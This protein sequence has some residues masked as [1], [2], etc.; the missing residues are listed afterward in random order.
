MIILNKYQ[1][2]NKAP[3]SISL[4][5][6]LVFL[7][8]CNNNPAQ[9][10]TSTTEQVTNMDSLV[11]SGGNQSLTTQSTLMG[12]TL[13]LGSIEV[14]NWPLRQAPCTQCEVQLNRRHHPDGPTVWLNIK[15]EGN[16]KTWIASSFK[17]QF[18]IDHWQFKHNNHQ[19][20]ISDS[21][22]KQKTTIAENIQSPIPLSPDNKCSVLWA[23]KKYLSQPGANISAD[24]AQFSSQFVI[25]CEQ[26][27]IQKL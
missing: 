15:G 14:K 4:L 7:Y 18:N 27:P 22:S 24:V 12:S 2:I 6:A 10:D 13:V 8:G 11:I 20:I 23:N 1:A 21:L 5:T 19:V 9:S 25:R 16:S 26:L 3:L 17:N